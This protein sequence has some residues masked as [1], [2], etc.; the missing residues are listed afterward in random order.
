MMRFFFSHSPRE[1]LIPRRL[2]SWRSPAAPKKLMPKRLLS[3]RSP[4]APL[5]HCAV[6]PPR[7]LLLLVFLEISRAQFTLI[8]QDALQDDFDVAARFGP[9]DKLLPCGGKMV[10]VDLDDEWFPLC[11]NCSAQEADCPFIA[12][13]SSNA[14]QTLSDCQSLC[15]Q[16]DNCTAINYNPAGSGNPRQ[17][18]CVLRACNDLPPLTD[19]DADGYSAFSY[20]RGVTTH[21]GMDGTYQRIPL[22]AKPCPDPNQPPAPLTPRSNTYSIGVVHLT[23]GYDRILVL[24]GDNQENNVYF[25][26]DCGITFTCYDVRRGASGGAWISQPPTQRNL[27]LTCRR[28]VRRPVV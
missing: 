1:I 23:S 20:H 19:P 26:E 10:F 5:L 21:I 16:Y 4:A 14:S 24:G 2:L 7:L 15:Q 17:G 13:F 11:Q 8:S 3:W 27:L 28:D 12:R 22:Y 6:T 9:E 18:D 25:S